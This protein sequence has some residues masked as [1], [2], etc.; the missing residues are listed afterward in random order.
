MN[1][2][3]DPS[4]KT[5]INSLL[6]PEASSAAAF[7]NHISN[8][9]PA[10]SPN[11]VPQHAPQMDPYTGSFVNGASFHLRAADW[12]DKRKVENG[13]TSAQR[14]YQQPPIDSS[15]VYAE[16]QHPRMARQPV[17]EPGNTYTSMADEVWQ[18]PMHYGA[19]VIAPLYS[20]ERTGQYKRPV[21]RFCHTR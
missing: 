9:A 17:D 11:H 1:S 5:S 8:L 21:I 18:P 15:E 19:P 6:N 10:L 7:S 13:A 16:A 4:K 14:H 2:I 3:H 20:D 12:S